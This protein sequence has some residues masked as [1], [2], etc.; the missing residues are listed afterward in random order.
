[1]LVVFHLIHFF[2][3]S[4]W[5]L[6]LVLFFEWSYVN[7]TPSITPPSFDQAPISYSIEVGEVITLPLTDASTVFIEKKILKA[8]II[9]NQL[10]LTG[11]KAG[12]TK[13]RTQSINYHITVLTASDHL[14]VKNLQEQFKN[15]P[16]IKISVTE[17][18]FTARGE[19]LSGQDILQLLSW[20][21]RDGNSA[22]L[23]LDVTYAEF[24]RTEIE[25]AFSSHLKQAISLTGHYQSKA[26][27][28]SS[29]TAL[30]AHNA[31]DE[32]SQTALKTLH[33]K[34]APT[35]EALATIQKLGLMH[36]FDEI[37]IEPIGKLQIYFAEVKKSTL[38]KLSPLLLNTHPLKD[39]SLAHLLNPE[40][41]HLHDTLFSNVGN[42]AEILIFDKQPAQIHS[43][44][45]FPILNQS[46]H[47]S[48][49]SWKQF[50]LFLN[51]TGNDVDPNSTVLDL[52]FKLSMVV[53]SHSD[54]SVPSLTSDSW[55]QKIRIA[56][57]QTYILKS[58]FA[59]HH[60][61]GQGQSAIFK[62][63]PLLKFLFQ[64]KNKNIGD[65]D[66]VLVL[67]LTP[68]V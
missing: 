49:V 40:Y 10:K 48:D 24:L 52:D 1:M 56:K 8:Q 47:S 9:G 7:A 46:F 31:Y 67:K 66:V 64:S 42:Q 4:L 32:P 21:G 2:I 20:T 57:N 25:T 65:T 44:G 12:Q 51:V 58:G 38:E 60:L 55:K 59:K 35:K 37:S 5:T 34:S 22:P 28:Y 50:G 54:N 18:G 39:L 45:E 16:A 36:D 33:F 63:I 17:K 14:L 13:L 61:Q 6:I 23:F 29:D 41:T 19:I 62:N 11:Q 3:Q 30:D 15:H 43:G 26:L 68:G 53:G 27:A